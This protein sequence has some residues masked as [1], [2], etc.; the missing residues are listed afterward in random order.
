MTEVLKIE[1]LSAGYGGALVMGADRM[2]FEIT[3]SV[4]MV[5]PQA[6]DDLVNLDSKGQPFP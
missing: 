2:A 5:P 4:K 6:I 1:G 3:D